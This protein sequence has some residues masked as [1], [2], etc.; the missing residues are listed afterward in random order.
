LPDTRELQ[1]LAERLYSALRDGL[2]HGFDTRH[3]RVDGFEHQIY[4]ASEGPQEFVIVENER[5][6]GLRIGI[7]LLA[8][9]LCAK[10]TDFEACLKHDEDARRRFM[11]ARQ[12]AADLDAREAEAWRALAAAAGAK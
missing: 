3:L 9:R 10:I 4:L 5:G 12:R 7:R 11:D 1:V 2:V 6:T 8:E